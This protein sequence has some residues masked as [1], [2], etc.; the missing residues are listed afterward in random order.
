MRNEQN[1][2][3][4]CRIAILYYLVVC[5]RKFNWGWRAADFSNADESS[6]RAADFSSADKFRGESRGF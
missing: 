3:D 5:K 2:G 1:W 6:W 4:D